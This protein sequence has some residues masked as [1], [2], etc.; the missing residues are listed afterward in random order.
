MGWER[1]QRGRARLKLGAA[2]G[3]SV[4]RFRAR[5]RVVVARTGVAGVA[6][7]RARGSRARIPLA[8]VAMI[9]AASSPCAV[10][11]TRGDV[12]AR[13]P[14]ARAARTDGRRVEA[15]RPDL[16]ERSSRVSASTTTF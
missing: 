16:G 5:E 7:D 4:V 15:Q 8:V 9:T 10:R 13:R 1:G 2:R 14:R 12:C 11:P 6:H 3:D